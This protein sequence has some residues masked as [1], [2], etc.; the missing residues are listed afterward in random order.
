LENVVEDSAKKYRADSKRRIPD[1][2]HTPPA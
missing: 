2:Q 1:W